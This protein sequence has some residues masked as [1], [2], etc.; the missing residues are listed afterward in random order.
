MKK[1]RTTLAHMIFGSFCES[2]SISIP[3]LFLS[4]AFGPM[5]GGYAGFL[6]LILMTPI[7]IISSGFGNYLAVEFSDLGLNK[8]SSN[9]YNLMAVLKKLCL[10][11]LIFGIAI[12]TF[13]EISL[14]KILGNEWKPVAQIMPL[15]AFPFALHMFWYSTINILYVRDIVKLYSKLTFIRLFIST[16][17]GLA[18][19][20]Q[21]YN[22]E[23][24]LLFFYVGQSIGQI[25]GLGYLFLAKKNKFIL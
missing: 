9:Y 16:I 6:S 14:E 18:I 10:I 22:W 7:T 24:V 2:L 1:Y 8:K 11:S 3:I 12:F 4:Y 5:Y 13:G 17:F 20:Y 23:L 25:I 19:F 15:L 21:G